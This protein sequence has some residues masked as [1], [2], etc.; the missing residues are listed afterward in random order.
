MTRSNCL[1]KSL[2]E[3]TLRTFCTTRQAAD[4]LGISLR[5]AQLWVENGLL[6]A[7]K[8]S[9]GHRRI[10]RESVD[11][12]LYRKEADQPQLPIA[13]SRKSSQS[14]KILVVEDDEIL[15]RLYSHVIP[16]WPVPTKVT[17]ARNGV[18]ALVKIGQ[19][20]PDFLITD[21]LMPHMDGF[22]MLR[23][24]RAM[25]EMARMSIV[26]VSGLDPSEIVKKGGI[27]DS[28]K[29]FPKPIPFGALLDIAQSILAERA[30]SSSR[31]P[32]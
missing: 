17:I 12:L 3:M 16:R 18:E 23:I 31:H 8:T 11:R 15:V 27:P 9:G 29:L 2:T 5:T 24:L 28:I 26:A 22:A 21:L 10:A 20:Q 6:E 14:L 7:W 13:L 19:E 30:L 4:L 25:P 1:E 32:S